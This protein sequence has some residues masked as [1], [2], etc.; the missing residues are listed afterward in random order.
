M[1]CCAFSYDSCATIIRLWGRCNKEYKTRDEPIRSLTLRAG[2]GALCLPHGRNLSRIQIQ[3]TARRH[4]PPA[5][6][7]NSEIGAPPSK[8]INR[9][10]KVTWFSG[11][12]RATTTT[13]SDPPFLVSRNTE[14]RS[15]NTNTPR[16]TRSRCVLYDDKQSLFFL[17][18]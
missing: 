1:P 12:K 9:T 8:S 10:Q 11:E 6:V 3:M 13:L 17:A 2:H 14:T 7:M 5:D 4:T 18:Q 16:V 15:V